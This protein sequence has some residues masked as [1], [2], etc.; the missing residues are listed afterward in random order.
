MNTIL[1]ILLSSAIASNTKNPS[2]PIYDP[3]KSYSSGQCVTDMDHTFVSL[4]HVPHQT[5]VPETLSHYPLNRHWLL[6]E[7]PAT[8]YKI[9]ALALQLC[10]DQKN[11]KKWFLKLKKICQASQL[12]PLLLNSSLLKSLCVLSQK[13]I[14]EIKFLDTQSTACAVMNSFNAI[15]TIPSVPASTA[16]Q[17]LP[18]PHAAGTPP[19][20]ISVVKKTEQ[21]NEDGDVFY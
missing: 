11:F 16:S 9:K 10:K 4:G 3:K 19:K 15:T 6:V 8:L 7:R 12:D 13:K 1:W 20:P 14:T 2:C 18:I 17:P 5:Q 21:F